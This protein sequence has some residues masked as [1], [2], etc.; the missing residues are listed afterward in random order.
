MHGFFNILLMCLYILKCLSAP[1]A[2]QPLQPLRLLGLYGILPLFI[3]LYFCRELHIFLS[4]CL[5]INSVLFQKK[6][7]LVQIDKKKLR[8]TNGGIKKRGK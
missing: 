1:S 2:P 8:K 3:S 4:L 6:S 7:P 5:Y